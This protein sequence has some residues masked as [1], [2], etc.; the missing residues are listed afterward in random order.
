MESS[1]TVEDNN[2]LLSS[3]LDSISGSKEV[4]LK[5]M[6]TSAISKIFNRFSL[7]CNVLPYF[8]YLDQ[9]YKLMVQLNKHSR[10]RWQDYEEEFCLNL[11]DDRRRKL[12]LCFSYSDK[13]LDWKLKDIIKFLKK[14]PIVYKIFKL[15]QLNIVAMDDVKALLNFCENINNKFLRFTTINFDHTKLETLFHENYSALLVKEGLTDESGKIHQYISSKGIFLDI[16]NLEGQNKT[17]SMVPKTTCCIMLSQDNTIRNDDKFKI[18][19]TLRNSITT[20]KINYIKTMT[21]P[22]SM[23]DQ[24]VRVVGWFDQIKDI[25][26]SMTQA[27][28]NI[29]T[30]IILNFHNIIAN[31]IEMKLNSY[32]PDAEIEAKKCHL[33]IRYIDQNTN[34]SVM[35]FYKAKYLSLKSSADILNTDSEEEWTPMTNISNFHVEGI[36][37]LE[38]Y[39]DFVQTKFVP[40]VNNFHF[41]IKKTDVSKITVKS[42]KD[43]SVVKSYPNASLTIDISE[44]RRAYISCKISHIY[45]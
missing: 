40:T 45:N 21:N 41:L 22:L 36:R 42:D 43:P 15:P 20:L 11:L 10:A 7:T 3:G 25:K 35:K 33:C 19:E 17:D 5:N 29:L 6:P 44:C 30:N 27:P 24:V 12:S 13:L 18:S 16:N 9:S 14:Y 37:E 1:K 8:G 4:E 31:S 2:K 26:F 28:D 38:D 23:C 32:I 39:K 34:N